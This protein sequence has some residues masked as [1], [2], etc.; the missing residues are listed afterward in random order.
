[1]ERISQAMLILKERLFLS[2]EVTRKYI[3]S[4]VFVSIV[5]LFCLFNYHTGELRPIHFMFSGTILA[6]YFFHQ[7]S[8][9]FIVISI[10]FLIKEMIFD[11]LRYVPF[12]WLIPIHVSQPY[13]IDQFLFGV[14]INGKIWLPH[15]L[16]LHF[17]HPFLDLFCG[18]L[19][20]A[21]VP[22]VFILLMVFWRFHSIDLAKRYGAA[23]LLMNLF[24]FATYVL[25]PAAAPWYISKYG[26]VQPIAAVL[27]DPAGLIK[28]DQLLGT[29]LSSAMYSSSPV[30]FGAIPSMHAGFTMLGWLY[31]F[32]LNKKVAGVIGLYTV[33]MWFS[34]LYLQHHYLIDLVIGIFYAVIA[35]LLIE[36]LLI[37]F[38]RKMYDFL[39]YYFV[40]EGV[41]PLFGYETLKKEE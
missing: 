18:F 37:R 5:I 2:N 11:T 26:F 13:Y 28:F 25:Y 38:I 15:E 24:A 12:S 39:F 33:S 23:F 36:K 20:H 19:Y 21:L 27:G 40:K 10:P 30:V 35:Y 16:L 22:I 1:M 3:F 8:R 6:L 29:H 4:S 41:R 9:A 34:A 7:Q 32:H 17:S 14:F 31:S